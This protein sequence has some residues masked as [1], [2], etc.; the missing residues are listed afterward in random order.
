MTD[1]VALVE[2]KAESDC[3]AVVV[4]ACRIVGKCLKSHKMLLVAVLTVWAEAF[5]KFSSKL[6][7]NEAE[8]D[9]TSDDLVHWL[10]FGLTLGKYIACAVGAGLK[11]SNW[12]HLRVKGRTFWVLMC[13]PASLDVAKNTCAVASLYFMTS[14]AIAGI[15][16]LATELLLLAA[17]SRA[18]L[19]RQMDAQ[20]WLWLC[21][22]CIAVGVILT[23]ELCLVGEHGQPVDEEEA[24]EAM[25]LALILASVV[26][27]AP[28][29][30][31]HFFP[32]SLEPLHSRLGRPPFAS[33]S[34]TGHWCWSLSLAPPP[35]P[36]AP[37]PPPSVLRIAA[38]N[39]SP[40]LTRR[41]SRPLPGLLSLG[42]T[43]ARPYLR[44]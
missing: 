30:P 38:H 33:L 3:G 1:R 43:G 23:V 21:V 6:I 7:Y 37:R 34:L 10:V 19:G 28:R 35:T 26:F 24:E 15:L 5:E 27:G 44:S 31:Q 25:A 14:A 32:R 17:L 36:P 29:R 41:D 13:V 11:P 20:S 8:T 16:R 40:P 18:V 4:D 39:P 9:G 42:L 22:V 12:A 2:D